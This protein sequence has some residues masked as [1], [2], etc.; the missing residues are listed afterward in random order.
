MLVRV[1]GI[2]RVGAYGCLIRMAEAAR[3]LPPP[4]P[5]YASRAFCSACKERFTGQVQLRLAIALWAKYAHLAETYE[6]NFSG[7]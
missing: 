1:P 3:A 6:N 4:A 7:V 2:V 5:P